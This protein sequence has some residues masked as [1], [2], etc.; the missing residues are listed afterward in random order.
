MRRLAVL[1][2]LATLSTP[3]WALERSA[4]WV[5]T[6]ISAC[7]GGA[8][9]GAMVA[10][11]GGAPAMAQTAGLFCGLSVVATFSAHTAVSAW[12]RA[13]RVIGW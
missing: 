4:P 6:T 2:L 1:A 7:A 12:R 8:A 9:I 3:V 10:Y 11:A 13:M 5:E